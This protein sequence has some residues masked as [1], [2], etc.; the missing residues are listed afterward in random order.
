[1]GKTFKKEKADWHSDNFSKK[2]TKKTKATKFRTEDEET[3]EEYKLLYRKR[4]K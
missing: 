1:M 4:F 2:L 3:Y